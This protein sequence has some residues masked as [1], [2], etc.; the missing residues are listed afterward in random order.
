MVLSVLISLYNLSR[1][2]NFAFGI[3]SYLFLLVTPFSADDYTSGYMDINLMIDSDGVV[4]WS[5]PARLKSSCKIDISYF[6]YD[7]QL[8]HLKFGSWT[9]DTA[10]VSCP[11]DLTN[12]PR[13]S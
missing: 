6:P 3:H 2:K 10:Q 12:W 5:P 7:T 8:C 13:S 11:S 1:T 4:N 9:Y